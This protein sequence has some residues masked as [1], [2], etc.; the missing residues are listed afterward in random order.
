MA[1]WWVWAVDMSVQLMVP[2]VGAL[3]RS[4]TRVTYAPRNDPP[5]MRPW[6][7]ITT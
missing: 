6:Y 3:V 7:L 5:E 2:G 4:S 1:D